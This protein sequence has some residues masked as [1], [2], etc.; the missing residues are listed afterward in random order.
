MP[1]RRRALALAAIAVGIAT[2]GAGVAVARRA[3][4]PAPTPPRAP[5]VAE[6]LVADWRAFGL[7]PAAPAAAA[8]AAR[9]LA[10]GRAALEA[11]LPARAAEAVRVY[12]LALAAAPELPA[13]AAGYAAAF[14]ATAGDDTTGG[15]LRAAHDLVRDALER[16]PGDGPLLAAYARLLL[17]VPSPANAAQ[18]REVAA[19]ALAAAPADAEVRLA[20]ALARAT[21]DPDAAAAA[22]EVAAAEHPADRRLLSA[23]A[24]A[25]W[26]AGD[27]PAALAL[28]GRRLALD[29]GHPGALAL[30]AE[31]ETAAGRFDAARAALARW[32]AEDAGA[33]E[34]ALLLARLAYQV[35]GDL[36]AAR[37]LLDAALAKSPGDFLA[38]RI[39]AHR[40]AVERAA[41][42]RAAATAA[43]EAALRRVPAS[44]PARFQAALLAF[45]AGAAAEVRASGGVVAARGGPA[46]RALLAARAAELSEVPDDAAQ[47]VLALAAATP[48]DPAALLAAGGALL[49][50]RMPAAA[51]RVAGD[52]LARDP[53]EARARRGPTDYWEGPRPLADAAARYAELAGAEPRRVDL[54]FTAAATCELLLG[55]TREAERLARAALAARPQATAP[56]AILAQVALER[57]EPRAALPLA[58][59]ASEGRPEDAFANAV[60]GRA[61]EA[62]GRDDE[63]GIAHRLAVAAVPDLATSRLAL[64]RLA[65]RQGEPGARAVL[66]ALVRD[67][68]DVWAA[69]GALLELDKPREVPAVPPR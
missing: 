66:A 48:R 42:D 63:A 4:A 44:A 65:V 60:R 32:M 9:H 16:A 23:A 55:H 53:L 47:V 52:A 7:V 5:T 31:I 43:V 26:A 19:R 29:A 33:A 21:D 67:E 3:L 12:R 18:A 28:A 1:P 35:D 68:P 56:L 27:A 10:D 37:T 59:A 62:L 41:G 38:A 8:D 58:R 57:G 34:P 14:A 22:L 45:E 36:A 39:L 61:L 64:A 49:R 51:L 50:L 54:A 11:D 24:R 15:D 6:S 40:A 46:V 30:V 13:A 2:L 25:R 17:A 20:A 69:R